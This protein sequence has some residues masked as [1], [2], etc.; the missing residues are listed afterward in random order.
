MYVNY[1]NNI[2]AYD[3]FINS[4][5]IKTMSNSEI[6]NRFILFTGQNVNIVSNN[7]YMSIYMKSIENFTKLET[8]VLSYYF[9]TL[10]NLQPQFFS[11]F[12]K[13]IN[14]IKLNTKTNFTQI[15]WGKPFTINHSIVLPK[16]IINNMIND[17]M[18]FSKELLKDNSIKRN[19]YRPQYNMI[20]KY[21][22]I[23]CHE[24]IHILQRH[25]GLYPQINNIMEDVYKNI[26]G[27]EKIDRQIEGL[28][29]LLNTI[30]NPDA[31]NFEYIN[32]IYNIE[33]QTINFVLPILALNDY[34]NLEQYVIILLHENNK[35]HITKHYNKIYNIPLYTSKF[36]GIESKSLINHPNEIF[37]TILSEFLIENK[38]Y[39]NEASLYLQNSYYQFY[40]LINVMFI[41]K[42]IISIDN[43]YKDIVGE[44]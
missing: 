22:N 16:Y 19:N 8:D 18:K 33:T 25:K 38:M 4:D 1:L 15:E 12:V 5:Y 37:A 7:D 42:N 26:W 41:N 13:P 11:Q 34:G 30:T 27:F 40:K 43:N 28:D 2:S 35:F 36:Y 14:V 32:K 21:L 23:L 29:N 20:N 10:N 24:L 17:Y 39:T 31:Y 3:E 44:I 6:L 9:K